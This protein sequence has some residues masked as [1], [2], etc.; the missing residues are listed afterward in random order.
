MH[1]GPP[2]P[3]RI[4]I[5]LSIALMCGIWGSTWIVIKSGLADLPPFTSAAARFVVA[6]LV[7]SAAAP[8]LHAREGG[9]APPLRLWVIVGAT[10]FGL[11]Y[12][13]VYWSET[14]LPSGIVALL[15]AVFPLIMAALAHRYVPGERLHGRQ[16]LGFVAGFAGI[17]L[18]FA[19][20]LVNFGPEGVPAACVL[21]VSP[22][23]SALGTLY[24]KLH[25]A[26]VSSV[27]TNRNGMC[28]GAVMLCAAALGAERGVA[29]HWTGQA[30]FSVAYL[31]VAGTVVTFGLYFWLL[32][33]A[34]AHRL[35]LISNV[36]PA[37]ALGL[38]W[39]VG[40][41][42]VTLHTLAGSALVLVGVLLVIWKKRSVD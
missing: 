30:L 23:V 9:A 24:L 31:A 29:A 12:G 15:W 39:S 8:F 41:E 27:L 28:L 22:L 17:A 20:D 14:R 10:N 11:S 16:W 19:T 18:L 5:A 34:P 38:G 42:P 1:A 37:I 26:G 35:S 7:M 2:A 6:A 4:K 32:R 13:I 33:H 36:T 40:G 21:L 25:G 3:S